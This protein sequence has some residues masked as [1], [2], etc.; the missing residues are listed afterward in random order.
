MV[1][2]RARVFFIGLRFRVR[3]SVRIAFWLESSA[4]RL[5][6]SVEMDELVLGLETITFMVGVT[7]TIRL[8]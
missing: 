8:G 7:V 5:R 6:V 3:L 4:F 2:D 1:W